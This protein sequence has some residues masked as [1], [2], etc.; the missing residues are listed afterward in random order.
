MNRLDEIE[1]TYLE[2]VA[3][4]IADGLFIVSD[5]GD[6][7][8]VARAVIQEMDERCCPLCSGKWTHEPECPMTPLMK[9]AD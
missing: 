4:G 1:E 5:V 7:L 8:A 9:D 6:L 2:K 3:N